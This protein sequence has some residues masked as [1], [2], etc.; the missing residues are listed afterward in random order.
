MKSFNLGEL[1]DSFYSQL[2]QFLVDGSGAGN[3]DVRIRSVQILSLYLL[4]ASSV[5]FFSLTK[6]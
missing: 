2:I 4:N 6:R 3:K 1:Y 5:R